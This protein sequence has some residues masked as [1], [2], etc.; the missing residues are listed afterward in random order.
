L[1]FTLL[2]LLLVTVLIAI[3]AAMLLPALA[4][5]KVRAKQVACVSQLRQVTYLLLL[6]LLLVMIA[7]E[8]I[9]RHRAKK[10]TLKE[11]LEA[12]DRE[13]E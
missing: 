2:E 8:V 11:V 3:L 5:A 9:R 13:T 7:F 6:L 4:R 10:Q 1:A 12:G